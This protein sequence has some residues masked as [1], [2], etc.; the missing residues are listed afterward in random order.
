MDVKF[1]LSYSNFLNHN[2]SRVQGEVISSRVHLSSCTSYLSLKC[3]ICEEAI[4]GASIPNSP[5]LEV[6][7][8]IYKIC[9][10]TCLWPLNCMENNPIISA[11]LLVDFFSLSYLS[12]LYSKVILEKVL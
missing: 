12:C 5:N 4:G 1:A 3:Q 7:L 10:L 2:S 11:L 8:F 6:A 9:S